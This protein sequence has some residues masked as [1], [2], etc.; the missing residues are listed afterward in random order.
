MDVFSN[1]KQLRFVAND[2]IVEMRLPELVSA[3]I[4]LCSEVAESDTGGS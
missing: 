4:T 3:D 2:M 1:C